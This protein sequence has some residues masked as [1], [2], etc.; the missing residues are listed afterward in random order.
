MSPSPL[1][2]EELWQQ[3]SPAMQAAIRLLMRYYE[4]EIATLQQQV[5]EPAQRLDQNS[6][7]S[8]RPPSSD[9]PAVKRRPPEPPSGRAGGGQPGPD[10]Q[11]RPLLPPDQII[12]CK[13]GSC[14]YCG[15]ALH[16]DDPSRTGTKY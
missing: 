1:I 11:Q 8:S 7:N 14:K 10:R 15:Y 6:T 13:P 5:S 2:S 3:V 9:G 16:G 12:D 4:Q